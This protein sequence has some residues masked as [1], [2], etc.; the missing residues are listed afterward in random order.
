MKIKLLLLPVEVF[1]KDF[2]DISHENASF[3]KLEDSIWL[4]LTY[5]L[6]TI[7][8]W[9]MKFLFQIDGDNLTVLAKDFTLYSVYHLNQPLGN[10]HSIASINFD[11]FTIDKSNQVKM[12]PEIMWCHGYFFKIAL[13]TRLTLILSLIWL[14]G[15]GKYPIRN[16]LTNNSFS[17]KLPI[18]IFCLNL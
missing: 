11:C 14:S 9:L 4:Q 10:I 12:S 16:L 1:S 5:F 15:S 7:A 6:I 8:F 3:G 17:L 18:I 13:G 2:V